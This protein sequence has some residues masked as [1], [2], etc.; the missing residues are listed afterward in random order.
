MTDQTGNHD[1]R[2]LSHGWSSQPLSR[3]DAAAPRTT[4]QA[5]PIAALLSDTPAEKLTGPLRTDSIVYPGSYRTQGS[6]PSGE[7]PS[8]SHEYPPTAIG[9]LPAMQQGH[10]YHNQ[11]NP[12]YAYVD[13]PRSQA[14]VPPLFTSPFTS[15]SAPYTF[16]RRQQPSL[17]SPISPSSESPRTYPED[18]RS[19]ASELP[20]QQ[21][22]FPTQTGPSPPDLEYKLIM[23]QQP[24]AARACGFGERD[25][26]VVD[27]PPIVE[28]RAQNPETGD[29]LLVRDSYTTLH[30]MLINANNG[31]DASQMSISRGE[32]SSA[33]RLMGCA[34][35]S[36][37]VGND[38]TGTPGSFFVFADLSV[39][40]SG[41]YKLLFRLLKVDP[42]DISR[43]NKN[44]IL[45]AIES[46]PFEVFTAKE[47]PG[48]RASSALLR[49]L[50]A[51]GLNV[52]VKKGSE[53]T[54]RK[55]GEDEGEEDD[56]DEDSRS[57]DNSGEDSEDDEGEGHDGPSTKAKGKGKGK[58]T[59]KRSR[60]Q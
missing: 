39:R 12:P 24:K 55:G 9:A 13:H 3:E 5:I 42:S 36:P 21:I 4:G 41:K 23:R 51:Q 37:W 20:A 49:A 1:E 16:H 14:A 45:A 57:N 28:V 58:A 60:R 29:S 33:Q 10:L 30:C 47:F 34:V 38:E 46:E 19:V 8:L 52:G 40:S 22:T 53:T 11:H 27:P 35:T 6:F 54:R 56:E 50:R 32:V 31:T 48:M 17:H 59:G 26:R 43:Q 15:A 44:F 2:R 18:V 7:R 25:R